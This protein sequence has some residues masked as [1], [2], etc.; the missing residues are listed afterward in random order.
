MPDARF[1]RAATPRMSAMSPML[2]IRNDAVTTFRYWCV[3]IAQREE[4][5]FGKRSRFKRNFDAEREIF[6]CGSKSAC[7]SRH[8]RPFLLPLSIGTSVVTTKVEF[9]G[10]IS[11][12]TL[13]GLRHDVEK[14]VAGREVKCSRKE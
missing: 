7:I 3:V 4:K 2:D 14:F 12:I 10:T 6:W 1:V 5:H 11:D 9:P 8:S 13:D